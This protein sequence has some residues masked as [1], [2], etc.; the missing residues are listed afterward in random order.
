MKLFSI[1]LFAF[2][3]SCQA[4]TATSEYSKIEFESGACFG[5]CPV[6]K[7]TISSDREALL[8][9]ERFNFSEE[10]PTKREG[11]YKTVIN[12][13]NF[14]QLLGLLHQLQPLSLQDFYGNKKIMDLPS[15][16]LRLYFQDGS[17]KQ[18]QDYGKAGTPQL[19]TLYQ[20]F[21]DL[22][23]TQNWSKIK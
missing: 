7:I 12:Q 20:F 5:K 3:L 15:S 17:Q 10:L 1:F 19:E 2:L 11:T 4:Q 22:K 13:E 23:T 21:E 14:N 18:I 9:A 6:Y 8:E 16:Y